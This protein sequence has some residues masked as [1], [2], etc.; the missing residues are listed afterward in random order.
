MKRPKQWRHSSTPN[1]CVC[2]CVFYY[3]DH[4]DNRSFRCSGIIFQISL[5]TTACSSPKV[6]VPSTTM[7]LRLF[8]QSPS[9]YLL[10]PLVITTLFSMNVFVFS[11]QFV[12]FL[13]F[14]IWVKYSI[15]RSSLDLISLSIISS[16]SIHVVTKAKFHLLWL[17]CIS[18]YYISYYLFYPFIRWM[19]I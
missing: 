15:Y 11:V 17:N 12:Y 10:L 3:E 5:D 18:L 6:W 2:V 13:I 1:C 19:D 16:K 8:T 9:T 7:L 4:I 14:G